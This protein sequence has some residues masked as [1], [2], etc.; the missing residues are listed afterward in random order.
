MPARAGVFFRIDQVV[1]VRYTEIGDHVVNLGVDH[2]FVEVR[3]ALRGVRSVMPHHAP[4][5]GSSP[6]APLARLAWRNLWRHRQ[7][8]VLLLVVVAYARLFHHRLLE[9]R[10]RVRGIGGA[11]VRPLH[12]RAR[13]I[14]QDAWFV[15]PDPENH[16]TDLDLLRRYPACSKSGRRRAR[17]TQFPALLQSAYVTQG[18]EVRGV[19]P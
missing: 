6:A 11:I 8:T 12:R 13:G 18:V 4:S 15:D 1:N 16:L 10:G 5:Q 2:R 19:D 9:L 17:G 7:R 3:P 14:A